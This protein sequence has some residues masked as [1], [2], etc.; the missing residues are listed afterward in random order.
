MVHHGQFGCH[1]S[2][3]LIGDQLDLFGFAVELVVAVGLARVELVRKL[4]VD[5][6][7]V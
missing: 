7:V 6:L 4:F 2:A 5:A 3:Q 1:L